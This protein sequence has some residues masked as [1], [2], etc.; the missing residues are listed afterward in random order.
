MLSRAVL[1]T[2]LRVSNAG[3]LRRVPAAVGS[4]AR[5]AMTRTGNKDTPTSLAAVQLTKATPDEFQRLDPADYFTENTDPSVRAELGR[6]RAIEDEVIASVSQ[7]VPTIDWDEWRKEIRY[8]GLVDELKRIHDSIQVPDVEKERENLVASMR[9]AF[10]PILENFKKLA[11]EAEE[12]SR[13]LEKRLEEVNYLHDNIADIPL[14]EFL[15][16]YPKVKEQIEDD[17]KNNRWFV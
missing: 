16:K 13:H 2:G 15:E 7:D 3:P 12:S 17:V 11:L 1:R 9:E 8:P 5:N 14:D 4:S 6:L 10:E